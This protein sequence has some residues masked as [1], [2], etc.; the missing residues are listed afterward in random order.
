MVRGVERADVVG[1]APWS[2]LV[3]GWL[4]SRLDLAPANVRLVAGDRRA[5]HLWAHCR[6]VGP[7]S[8]RRSSATIGRAW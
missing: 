8:R 5:V 2:A 4:T 1:G 7:R 3:G 6:A